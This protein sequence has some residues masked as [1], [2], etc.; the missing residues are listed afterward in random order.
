MVSFLNFP[1]RD[2]LSGKY[3]VKPVSKT[4]KEHIPLLLGL[5]DEHPELRNLGVITRYLFRNEECEAAVWLS[6]HVAWFQSVVIDYF[7]DNPNDPINF[8]IE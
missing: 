6:A 8:D 2:I 7:Y 1:Y 4:A 3:D 5:L